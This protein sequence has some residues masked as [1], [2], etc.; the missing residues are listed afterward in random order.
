[1]KMKFRCLLSSDA[2][3]LTEMG[4]DPEAAKYAISIYPRTEH[5]TEDSVKRELDDHEARPWWRNSTENL[6]ET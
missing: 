2:C 1:M 6:L 5:E 3:W 4:N